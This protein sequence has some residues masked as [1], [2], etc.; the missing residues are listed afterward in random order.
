M[1]HWP[2]KFGPAGLRHS[3]RY[4][5][6]LHPEHRQPSHK[7]L[8]PEKSEPRLRLAN[9]ELPPPRPHA[10]RRTRPILHQGQHRAPHRWQPCPH[11][12]HP[13]EPAYRYHIPHQKLIGRRG[14]WFHSPARFHLYPP[15][16]LKPS[17][18]QLAESRNL[19]KHHTRTPNVAGQL[20]EPA[21][22]LQNL[23]HSPRSMKLHP[24]PVSRRN[25]FTLV[26]LLVTI[27]IIAALATISASGF[28]AMRNKA[29]MATEINGARNLISAY[30]LHA[31]DHN[32]K[33]L[34]GFQTD[35]TTEDLN[36]KSLSYPLN[37]RYP[38]RLASYAPKLDGVF[39][40]NGNERFL[41]ESNRNYLVS[42]APNLGINATLV[43]GHY[44]SGSPLP[45]SPRV[46]R[47][48]GRFYV[49]R[50]S[51][52]AAPDKLIIFASA[53]AGEDSP[54]YFEVRPPNLTS[55]VWTSTRF[56]NDTPAA[57]HGFVDFRWND[58][59]VVAN[60]GGSVEVLT[61]T[62]LR[63]MR[64]WSN[65]AEQNNDSEFIIKR[66]N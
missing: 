39:V 21:T 7:K 33:L 48:F 23:P 64:R 40:Y 14:T 47:H 3:R 43:G 37:A 29:K 16:Q 35:N 42:V 6:Q 46:V 31:G 50:L 24:A 26:E 20:S 1:G 4:T 28:A 22:I 65:Q 9:P 34:P 38:W 56:N 49:D 11:T 30:L 27:A 55:R 62:Q 18:K 41:N 10:R 57:R 54:G 15:I 66:S 25:G 5:I 17:G 63:D 58:K 19:H 61:E 36:G 12:Q 8:P 53:R 59:A 2:N 13:M 60:L 52:V 51:Q 45:P 44:G 32:G